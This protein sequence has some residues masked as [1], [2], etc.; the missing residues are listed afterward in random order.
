MLF[1]THYSYVHIISIIIYDFLF[2]NL[3]Q[4]VM[5]MIDLVHNFLF[6]LVMNKWMHYY[7]IFKDL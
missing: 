6:Y 3:Y 2:I 1:H 5:N 4:L 7:G